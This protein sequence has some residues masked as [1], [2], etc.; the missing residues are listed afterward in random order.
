MLTL[1]L[2]V[3]L[4]ADLTVATLPMHACAFRPLDGPDLLFNPFRVFCSLIRPDLL[5][6]DVRDTALKLLNARQIM[7][8]SMHQLLT[9]A[10]AQGGVLESQ[11]DD[12]MDL[13]CDSLF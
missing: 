10:E 8:D 5:E 3:T 2:C 7:S 13:F 6:P 12:C 1:A 11:V 9:E 4:P